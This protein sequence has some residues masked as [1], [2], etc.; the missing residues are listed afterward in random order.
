VALLSL[1]WQ[2]HALGCPIVVGHS[3]K[4]F[5]GELVGDLAADRTA[6]TI[7][8]ALALAAQGVQVL[9]VHDVA[10]VRQALLL[11]EATRQRAVIEP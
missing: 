4:R 10:A 7:G 8:V 5:I 6:G 2:L 3:R 1:A 9:R 11:Y